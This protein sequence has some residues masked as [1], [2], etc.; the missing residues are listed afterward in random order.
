MTSTTSAPA[1]STRRAASSARSSAWGPRPTWRLTRIA[2][3][4]SGVRGVLNRNRHRSRRD[5]RGNRVL[6]HH[7]GH[8]VLEEDDVLVEGF[9]LA[10][11]LDAVHQVDRDRNMLLAQRVEERILQQ[12]ALVAHC[13]A[14]FISSG[15]S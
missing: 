3:E 6:V 7:L 8:G 1:V 11:E 4:R 15:F 12:L 14:P 13:Y 9:D 2:R 5:D 10:L